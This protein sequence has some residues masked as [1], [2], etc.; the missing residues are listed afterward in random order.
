MTDNN[1]INIQYKNVLINST[2]TYYLQFVLII[3]LFYLVP[4]LQF[5]FF[6]TKSHVVTCYYNNLCNKKLEN[7]NGF[8]NV[9]SNVSYI[10]LGLLF[11]ITVRLKKT[12]QTEDIRNNLGIYENKSLYYSLGVSFIF[13]GLCSATYHLCPSKLNLQFDTTFMF[14]CISLILLILYHK[15]NM[16]NICHPLKFYLLIFLVILLNTLSLIDNKTSIQLWIWA[17]TFLF[18]C[19]CIISLT[20]YVYIGINVEFNMEYINTAWNIAKNEKFI[21]NPRFWLILIID[22][23]TISMCVYAGLT[24]PYYTDWILFISI[25]NLV[26]YF[27]YYLFIKYINNETI[28]NYIKIALGVDT[29][30]GIASLYFYFNTNYNTLLPINESNKLNEHCILLNYFD[31]HDLWHLLSAITLYIFMNI[32]L[33]IDYD[34]D[35]NIREILTL[36]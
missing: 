13:E 2:I 8:N 26:I 10:I 30:T 9:I 7:L 14:V 28:N 23:F 3:G 4:A 36:L 17:V 16:G 33:F 11:I 29:I 5:I 20:L 32:I 31:N 34:I 18:V 25:V 19:Y 12:R 21:K 6:Q 27:I 35:G 22:T 1:Y 24:A 15:R